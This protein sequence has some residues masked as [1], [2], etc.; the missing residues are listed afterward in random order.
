MPLLLKARNFA[1][2]LWKPMA[3]QKSRKTP[4]HLQFNSLV[5]EDNKHVAKYLED[6]VFRDILHWDAL[7][8]AIG[9]AFK[10]TL[11]TP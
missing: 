5:E 7:M 8:L 3:I 1:M 6:F 11:P 10:I 4:Y 2:K 9:S